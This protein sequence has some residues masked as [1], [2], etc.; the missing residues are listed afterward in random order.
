MSLCEAGSDVQFTNLPEVR[1][2]WPSQLGAETCFSPPESRGGRCV[3]AGSQPH[4]NR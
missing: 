4:G 3:I 1:P 2:R